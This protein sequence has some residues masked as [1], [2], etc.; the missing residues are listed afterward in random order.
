MRGSLVAIDSG[1]EDDDSLKGAS[2]G[3]GGALTSRASAHDEDV[4][5]RGCAHIGGGATNCMRVERVAKE[6]RSSQGRR[7]MMMIHT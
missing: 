1:I 6:L 5:K 3:Q 7:R 4:V 2:E